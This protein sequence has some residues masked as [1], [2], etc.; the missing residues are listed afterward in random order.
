MKSLFR[1]FTFVLYL[2]LLIATL[3]ILNSL[4]IDYI[5]K[6]K[7]F[8]TV[9]ES[10]AHTI[11]LVFGTSKMNNLGTLNRFFLYRIQQTVALY[12]AGKI[13]YILISGDN[14][15]ESYD[16]PTSFKNELIKKW[17]PSDRIVLDYAGLSTWDSIARAKSIFAVKD[18]LLISQD[19]QIQRWI[20]ACWYHNI[21]CHGSAT[22]SISF[23]IAPRVY[24]REYGAR[25]K[26]WYDMLT[27][28][29]DI[30]GKAEEVP[31]ES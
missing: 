31:R 28:A 30:G 29:P 15:K 2:C 21:T 3:A 8:F 7:V 17:I 20:I 18:L 10:P 11:G 24:L 1:F 14:R 5:T 4:F 19:F 16:E 6:D 22:D 13:Q 27:P 26:L 23:R 25:I 12:K 9:Q